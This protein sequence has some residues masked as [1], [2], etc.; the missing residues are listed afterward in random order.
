MQAVRE[1]CTPLG[2][3]LGLLQIRSPGEW[4]RLA[5]AV[6]AIGQP[7][8]LR[9]GMLVGLVCWA[10]TPADG[11]WPVRIDAIRACGG[12]GIVEA[13]FLGGSYLPDGTGFIETAYADGVHRVLAI[14]VDGVVFRPGR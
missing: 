5:S 8:D 11:H 13:S 10:G 7:P 3:R 2:S 12:D 9:R 14:E 4:E 6:P 1:L